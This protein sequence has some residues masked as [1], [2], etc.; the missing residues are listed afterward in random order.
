MHALD[1]TTRTALGATLER[2][3]VWLDRLP[4]A[5]RKEILTAPAPAERRDAVRRV[6]ERVWREAL[7]APSRERL[8][9]A[10][11]ADRDR[12]LAALHAAE[13]ERRR[14]WELAH[15]EWVNLRSDGKPWPFDTDDGAKAVEEYVAKSLR[16]RLTFE[17]ARALDG[18][19]AGPGPAA[20]WFTWSFYGSRVAALA[21]AHPGLPEAAPGKPQVMSGRDFVS[22]PEFSRQFLKASARKIWEKHPASGRWPDF[23]EAV[24]KEAAEL[25][26]PIRFPLGP[27][28]PDDYTPAVKAFLDADL[29]PRLDAK[30]RAELKDLESKWPDHPRRVMALA[31]KYDLSVPGVSPPGTPSRWARQYT[32]P[33]PPKR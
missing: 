12:E 7:P 13:A 29:A 19:R 4:D 22:H 25:K 28:R 9:T 1:A 5:Y 23:A 14:E 16:P 2:Y 27:A 11:V 30:E 17:E 32:A 33:P 15:R 24:M 10:E 26:V 3:A 21:E 6:K 8:Q 31:R 18:L 20:G